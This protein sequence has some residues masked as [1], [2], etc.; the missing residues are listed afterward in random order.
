MRRSRGE[1]TL[2]RD[3]S[4]RRRLRKKEKNNLIET[5]VHLEPKRTGVQLLISAFSG[6]PSGITIQHGC[7]DVQHKHLNFTWHLVSVSRPELFFNL[8][9][10]SVFHICLARVHQG[11]ETHSNFLNRNSK[12]MTRTPPSGTTFHG[13]SRSAL[14]SRSKAHLAGGFLEWFLLHVL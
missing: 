2:S 13:S 12:G 3:P 4:S 11:R 10:C 5:S 6:A 14:P 1:G 8:I 9:K 7:A